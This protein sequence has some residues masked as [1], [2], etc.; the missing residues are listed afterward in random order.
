MREVKPL[1]RGPL[2]ALGAS[3]GALASVLRRPT[4][5]TLVRCVRNESRP[6]REAL[7]GELWALLAFELALVGALPGPVR[8]R[9]VPARLLSIPGGIGLS[10]PEDAVGITIENGRLRVERR[11][12]VVEID[13]ERGAGAERPYHRIDGEIMLALADNNPL[14]AVEAHPDKAGNAIDLGGLPVSRWTADLDR[15]FVRIG[16]YL[17]EI[18]REM[19]LF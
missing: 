19:D 3:P 6:D 5:G 4:V 8:L 13:L 2:G 17:P 16:R 12:G 18:R 1:L 11:G 10:L 7:L 14:A 9:R 15:A